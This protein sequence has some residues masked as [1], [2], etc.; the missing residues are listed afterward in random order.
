M[1]NGGAGDTKKNPDSLTRMKY[2]HQVSLTFYFDNNLWTD[3]PLI[4]IYGLKF[5]HWQ[6]GIGTESTGHTV[7]GILLPVLLLFCWNLLINIVT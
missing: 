5:W 2:L 1:A 7:T 3:G 4:V 6:Y